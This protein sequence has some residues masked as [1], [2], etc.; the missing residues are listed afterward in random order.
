[1]NL[2][3][4]IKLLHSFYETYLLEECTL[5]NR[6]TKENL[7]N[8]AKHLCYMRLDV[9]DQGICYIMIMERIGQ[10]KYTRV[11]DVKSIEYVVDSETGELC[12]KPFI[13]AVVS[14]LYGL[15]SICG[16]LKSIYLEHPLFKGTHGI[17]Q[18]EDDFGNVYT[19]YVDKR[20][21]K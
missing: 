15:D 12:S 18:L 14:L 19:D 20:A 11:F 10:K 1:M 2:Q 7:R 6:I 21:I 5:F 17:V 16:D 3:E 9:Y 4:V 8:V 13:K